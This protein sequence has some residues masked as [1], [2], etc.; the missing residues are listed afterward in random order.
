MQ[1]VLSKN[2]FECLQYVIKTFKEAFKNLSKLT[3]F[4][5][6]RFLQTAIFDN[7]QA[8]RNKR[9]YKF[10]QINKRLGVYGVFDDPKE[11][12]QPCFT[13]VKNA[14]KQQTTNRQIHIPLIF[15]RALQFTIQLE[16]DEQPPRKILKK[17]QSKVHSVGRHNPLGTTQGTKFGS[18]RNQNVLGSKRNSR[19]NSKMGS[20]YGSVSRRTN[21][22][23][24]AWSH[25]DLTVF[26]IISSIA[27]VRV[28]IFLNHVLQNEKTK[29]KSNS[30]DFV[31][32]FIRNKTFKSVV[33][34]IKNDLPQLFGYQRCEL[35]L[36]DTQNKNM[37]S[38]AIDEEA[39]AQEKAEGPPGFEL[40]YIVKEKQIVRF[41]L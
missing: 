12:C 34:S 25:H 18:S 2:A 8:Q 39:E 30:I 5:V 33:K 9:H 10:L 29:F 31:A 40:E 20:E 27:A 36:H 38:C 24:P 21:S 23:R 28:E 14:A 3:I 26:R 22:L 1:I 35:F 41:P 15:N 16:L 17:M 6:N 32:S 11:F 37:Y 4:V 13:S 7:G 19:T